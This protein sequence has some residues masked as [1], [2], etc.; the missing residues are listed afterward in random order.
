MKLASD[1]SLVISAITL[2]VMLLAT[3]CEAAQFVYKGVYPVDAVFTNL[4]ENCFLKLP[5]EYLQSN[6]TLSV[7]TDNVKQLERALVDA[8]AAV[9]WELKKT[10]DGW[11]AQPVQNDGNLV[12]ISCMT[13]EPVNVPRYLYGFA[14]RSDSIKCA[15]RD[16]TRRHVDSLEAVQK[17]RADSLAALPPLEYRHY[18]LRYYSYSQSFADRMGVGW[19]ST[20]ALGNLHDKL[21]IFDDWTLEATATNDTAFTN[22]RLLFSLDSTLSVDWGSEEQ[23]L[24]QTFVND[25]V[26][27]QDYEWRKYGLI[28]TI[29]RDGRRTR[30]QYTFRDKAS[31]VSLL[32]GSAIGGEQDTIRMQ[33][34]YTAKRTFT[35]GIPFLSALPV[36]G[37]LFGTEE[38][39]TEQRA[40]ELYLVPVTDDYRRGQYS[41]PP[42][43]DNTPTW[44]HYGETTQ[45]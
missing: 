7:N 22:R 32:Q 29:Q 5:P 26:T 20:W 43:K 14:M 30:M 36:V 42:R 3:R 6:I 13:S 19:P 45:E 18:E 8:S 12:Y 33:G 41:R 28:V 2:S 11:R 35:R 4:C 44:T 31:G 10:R 25:G 1:K 23:T 40:F 21:E 16:S 15:A 37:Y 38:T 34:T 27:T 24:K 9:G 17:R 39:A